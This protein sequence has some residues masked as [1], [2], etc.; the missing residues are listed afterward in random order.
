MKTVYSVMEEITNSDTLM[1]NT[2][3]TLRIIDPNFPEEE[4]RFNAARALF[5]DKVGDSITPSAQEYLKA[6][7]LYFAS[8]IL[9]IAGQGFLL[10]LDIFRQPAHSLFLHRCEFEDLNRERMLGSVPGVQEAGKTLEAFREALREKPEAEAAQIQLL[11]EDITSMYSYLETSGYK[12]AHYFGF[13]LADRLLPFL[14]PGYHCDPVN[15]SWYHRSVAEYL[16]VDLNKLVGYE[17]SRQ[18]QVFAP[19][20]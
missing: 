17:N 8:S 3:A 18:A 13:A 9:Y 7:D 20:L 16:H 1:E 2:K 10:N 15:S 11:T 14:L 19:Q 5:L 12:L 4:A 6:H